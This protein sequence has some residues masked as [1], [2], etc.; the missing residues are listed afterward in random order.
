MSY[1]TKVSRHEEQIVDLVDPSKKFYT[2]K[3]YKEDFGDPKALKVKVV[4]QTV[5][6]KKIQGVVVQVGEE[7]VFDFI[8]TSR[9]R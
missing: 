8:S 3:K 1:K 9:S 5:N 4:T 7:G 2:L 6:G